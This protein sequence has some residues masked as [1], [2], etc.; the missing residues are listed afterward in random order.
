VARL[1]DDLRAT[2]TLLTPWWIGDRFLER[3][4]THARRIMQMIHAP[5]I[6]VLLIDNV[7]DY[8][9]NG[10]DQ[11]FWDLTRDFPNLAPPYEVFWT[12]H[13]LPRAIT[14]RE[15]GKTNVSGH[16]G[17]K[18][19]MGVLWMAATQWSA[20]GDAPENTK[21]VICAELFM[22]YDLYDTPVEGPAGTWVL[23][24]DAEGRLLGTPHLQCFAD[25]NEEHL[26]A[27]LTWLH[28]ALLAVSFL[29]CKNVKLVDEECP[30]PLA[31]KYHARTGVWPTPYH[32]LEIE[33]L[34]AILRSQGRSHE[35]GAAKAMHICRG[36]FRDYREGRG[37]FGRYKQLV[38]TPAVVRGTKGEKAAPREI[39]I[40]V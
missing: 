2:P 24:V 17:P 36:H 10:T 32:T 34:K 21:W 35:V 38:W 12:E 11:E 13:K 9:F 8:Y 27:Y 37:L 29:H 26:R 7:A 25:G 4:N 33:P 23:T 16:T 19:R 20:E 30:K 15:Y 22:D 1:I 5:D 39:R 40:K 31:K 14:S 6:P 18:A 3:F 28:P